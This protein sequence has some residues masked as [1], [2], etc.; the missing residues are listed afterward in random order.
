MKRNYV[1]TAIIVYLC[2]SLFSCNIQKGVQRD[3]DTLD[4]SKPIR[5]ITP[6]ADALVRGLTGNAVMGVSDSSKKA[7]SIILKN[8]GGAMDKMDPDIKKLLT[9]IST[10][11]DTTSLQVTKIGNSLHWQVGKLNGD[12]KLM[13]STVEKIVGT[14]KGDTKDILSNMIEN[15]L[16]SL[17]SP[18]SKVKIDSIISNI[19]DQNTKLKT[20]QFVNGALQPTLDSLAFKLHNVVYEDI[21]FVKKQAYWFIAGLALIAVLIIGFVWYERSKYARLAKVLT[22]QI[23]KIPAQNVYDELTNNIKEHAQREDLEPLLQK[24]L[25]TQGIN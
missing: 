19:L 14:L 12:I 17:K 7:L 3:I 23:D 25:K 8:L 16:D 11:G 4:L 10:V 20:Q 21:P 18:S 13:G 9:V 22:Y 2:I 24:I 6:A 5:K 1:F 15:A